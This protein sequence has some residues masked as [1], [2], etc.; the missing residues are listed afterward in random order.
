[1]SSLDRRTSINPTY[2]SRPLIPAA[3]RTP[4]HPREPGA[5]R[6]P[7]H[8]AR[9]GCP[10]LLSPGQI[11][12]AL[13]NPF[14]AAGDYKTSARARRPPPA[15]SGGSA[16]CLRGCEREKSWVLHTNISALW[17]TLCLMAQFLR[18]DPRGEH[19]QSMGH[20]RWRRGSEVLRYVYKIVQK[21]SQVPHE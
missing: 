4:V 15:R 18:G 5:V 13:L 16:G 12:V 7:P 6:H 2:S 11:A 3:G 8:F 10:S 17:R 20:A 1:V 14:C 9:L 19:V 21:T